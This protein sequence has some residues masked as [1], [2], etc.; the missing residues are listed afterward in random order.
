[1][2]PPAVISDTTRARAGRA[3]ALCRSAGRAHASR[4]ATSTRR[5]DGRAGTNTKPTPHAPAERPPPVHSHGMPRR[6]AQRN[7][8]RRDTIRYT[9]HTRDGTEPSPVSTTHTYVSRSHTSR[10][11]RRAHSTFGRFDAPERAGLSARDALLRACHAHSLGSGGPQATACTHARAASQ[12]RI[13]AH[14]RTRKRWGA[15]PRTRLRSGPLS[16]ALPGARR[17][18]TCPHPRPLPAS[19]P[20]CRSMAA[21]RCPTTPRGPAALWA[22]GHKARARVYLRVLLPSRRRRRHCTTQPRRHRAAPWP[23]QT[24]RDARTHVCLHACVLARM[25]ACL[26]AHAP[27]QPRRSHVRRGQGVRRRPRARACE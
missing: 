24:T 12:P 20:A 16:E 17:P 15:R 9:P 14:T 1:M 3:A 27:P 25:C 7:H 11:S 22:S 10:R 18:S 4:R 2:H 8:A 13:C 21:T 5:D 19:L 6:A 23:S 26:C